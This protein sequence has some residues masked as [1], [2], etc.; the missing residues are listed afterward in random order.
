MLR[1][2]VAIVSGGSSGLGAATSAYIVR[3]GG[4]VVV[5]DLPSSKDHFL[6]LAAVSCAEVHHH[7]PN[8]NAVTKTNDIHEQMEI[9]EGVKCR[10][11]YP[12][13]DNHSQKKHEKSGPL[14]AFAETDVRNEEDVKMALDLAEEKFG[15]PG[16]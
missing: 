9:A 14:M 10:Y 7:L 12:H 8:R 15:Q 11:Y 6:R 5:A 13:D 1:N 2:V 4:R 3:H 16:K